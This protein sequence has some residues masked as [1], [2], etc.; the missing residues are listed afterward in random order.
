MLSRP[1]ER[2]AVLHSLSVGIVNSSHADEVRGGRELSENI[3]ENL[4]TIVVCR[5]QAVRAIDFEKI[6]LSRA[7]CVSG[8]GRQATKVGRGEVQNKVDAVEVKFEGAGE[9]RKTLNCAV[10]RV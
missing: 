4:E 2:R 6:T 9:V 3:Q 8:S 5:A 1:D 7:H 10:V